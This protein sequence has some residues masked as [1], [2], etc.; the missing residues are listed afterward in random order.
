[1]LKKIAAADDTSNTVRLRRTISI[2]VGSSSSKFSIGAGKG[3]IRLPVQETARS[4][5]SVGR[6]LLRVFHHQHFHGCLALLQLQAQ[7]LLKSGEDGGR[8]LL[9]CIL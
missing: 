4:R 3:S 2:M 9:R 1:M 8:R 5:R 6:R 7:L